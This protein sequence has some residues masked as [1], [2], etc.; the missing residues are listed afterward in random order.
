MQTVS[1]IN[2]ATHDTAAICVLKMP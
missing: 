1:D 2:A